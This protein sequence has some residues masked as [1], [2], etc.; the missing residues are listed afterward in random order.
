VEDFERM[1]LTG[2]IRDSCTLAAWGLYLLWK[3][4]RD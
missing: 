3:A 2:V 1:M 4:R